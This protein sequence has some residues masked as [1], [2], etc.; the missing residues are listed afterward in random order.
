[1]LAASI[2]LL[3]GCGGCGNGRDSTAATPAAGAASAST[4][5]PAVK[6]ARGVKLKKIGSFSSPI[7]VTAPR[8]DTHRLFVVE[9]AGRI[10][11]MR[12]GKTLST[13]FLDISSNVRTDSERGLLSMAFAPDYASSGRFYIYFTDNTGDIRIQEYRR[14][15]GNPDVAATGSVRN[16]LTIRHREF[17]NHDGGQL[18][19]GPDNRLYAGIGDGGG[20]GD[21]HGH[22]QSRGTLLAKLLRID[23]RAPS[24]GRPYGVKGNPFV[25][26]SGAQPEIWAFGLRN[27]WRFSFDRSTGDLV[28]A[29]VGQDTEEEIDFARRGAGRGA[30]YGWNIFEGRR[31]FHS[32]SAPKAVRPRVVHD[33]SAG[34]CSITGGYVVRDKSLGSLYGRYVYGDLCKSPLRSVKLGRNGGASGDKTIGVS[35]RDLV[36]FGED[37]RG[38]MYAV[39]LDGGVFR[40]VPR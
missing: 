34:Y 1:M 25:S 28:I 18:Q 8:G 11:V 16:L 9:R 12:D 37:A 36:S 5:A 4:S 30:N 22:G 15:A 32:G 29:D 40:L 31:R 20:A 2:S 13:P 35:V 24:G 26:R 14:S 27:P 10:R 21:P 38:R 19:F 7:F 39:S 3:A 17:S 33:H 6:A 23:P